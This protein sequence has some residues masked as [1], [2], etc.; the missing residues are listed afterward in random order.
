MSDEQLAVLKKVLEY[1][2]EERSDYHRMAG[3][4]VTSTKV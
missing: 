4:R 1:L 3:R 2:D